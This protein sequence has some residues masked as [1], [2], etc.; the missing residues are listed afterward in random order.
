MRTGEPLPARSMT[1]CG[2]TSR[3]I[4]PAEWRCSRAR[5]RCSPG[6]EALGQCGACRGILG[7]AGEALERAPERRLARGV[8]DGAELRR[9]VGRSGVGLELGRVEG[10]R[11]R[12]RTAPLGVERGARGV[13]GFLP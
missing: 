5:A 8:G 11:V 9:R 13:L 10:S 1:F 12:G 7:L 6:T 4:T 3:W 2:F